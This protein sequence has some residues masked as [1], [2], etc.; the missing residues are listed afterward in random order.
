ML[1]YAIVCGALL[2]M[3]IRRTPIPVPPLTGWVLAFVVVVVMQIVN[4]AGHSVGHST[5]AVR[6]HL[7]FVPLFFIGSYVLRDGSR[8]R[9]FTWTLLG[10][11]AVNGIVN[12]IQ[13]NLSAEQIAGWGPGYRQFVLGAPDLAARVFYDVSG[14]QHA[15]PFGL[16]SDLGFGGFVGMLAMPGAL[17]LIMTE[18]RRRARLLA[19]LLLVATVVGVMTSETRIVVVGSIL[20]LLAFAVLVGL[21]RR[22]VSSL[23]PLFIGGLVTAV[24]V[25]AVT[26]STSGG[27][28]DRYRPLAPSEALNFTAGYRGPTFAV[29]PTYIGSFPLGAGLG[30]IGP[31]STL[32]PADQRKSLNGENELTFLVIELGLPGLLILGLFHLRLLVLALARIDRIPLPRDRLILAGVAAPLFAVLATWSGGVTTATTPVAPYFWLS[33]GVLC[34]WLCSRG[35]GMAGDDASSGHAAPK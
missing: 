8:L 34:T 30:S 4:P 33:A 16:G 31:A 24:A 11:A 35:S 12:F 27:V 3:A 2:R 26:S 32:T 20:A 29:L 9:T 18:T 19:G 5:A 28:F 23:T 13:F 21:S 17:A 25:I 15:R 22:A 14:V 1:L 6:Q 7:E 10:I